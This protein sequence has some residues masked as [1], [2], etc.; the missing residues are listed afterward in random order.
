MRGILDAENKFRYANEAFLVWFGEKD[1]QIIRQFMERT[2]SSITIPEKTLD[3][4]AI[5]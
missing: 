3:N 4:V 1:P 2:R 5:K